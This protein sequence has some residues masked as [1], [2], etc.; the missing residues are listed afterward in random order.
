MH[1]RAEVR[2]EYTVL[3]FVPGSKPF[4]LFDRAR[5][6]RMKLYV[7]RVFITDEVEILL[8]YL[9]FVR[10]LVDSADLPLNVSREII[11]ESPILAAIKK[12]VTG[13]VLSELEKL[14]RDNAEPYD[15][16]WEA[17][18]AVLKEGLYEDFERRSQLLGLARFKTTGGGG[19]RSISD[20]VGSI[21]RTRR[22]STTRRAPTLAA[23]RVRLSSRASARAD[24]GT[25]LA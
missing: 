8:R 9:R 4:D 11:Q 20:Y 22:R 14:A 5:A 25:A 13:R 24:R 6:G 21:K 10:G 1:F 16:V 7:K 15:K 12:G 17:F 3:G 2:H 23:L 18:G 19:W